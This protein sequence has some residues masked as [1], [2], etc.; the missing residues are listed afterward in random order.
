MLPFCEPYK[1]KMIEPLYRSSRIDRQKWIQD[2]RYNIFN[3]KS[4]QVFIDFLTDSGTGAMSDRQW[5]A[6]MS[7][8]E[9]YAGSRSFHQLKDTIKELTGFNFLLPTHQGRAAENVLFSVLVKEGH[10]VPGNAHFDTT[11]GHI[12]F[13]K[14]TAVDCTID[15][16]YDTTLSHPFK[17]NVN[18]KKLESLLRTSADKVSFILI[19]ATCNTA[20]GQPVS[21]DNIKQVHR[22]AKQYGKLLIM[23]AAR[24]AENAYF[25]KTREEGFK[26]KSI[27][28]IVLEMFSYFDGATMSAKKDGIVNIGGFIALNDQEL[29]REAS[30]F[31]IMFEGFLT[32]G[33]QAGRDM[34][35]LAQGLMESTEFDYLESRI[36]Q[37]AYL[38]GLLKNYGVPVQ[39]PFGGHAIFID[40]LRF[41]P[42]IPREEF[43]GQ[44]LVIELYKS[45]GIRSAEIGSLMADRDPLTRENRFPELELVRLAIPRRTYTNNHMDYTAAAVKSVLDVS[46][47]IRRGYRLT[48]E[49]P[50]MR[51]F[52]MELEPI[53]S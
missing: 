51:H 16:A 19:T 1:I 13:R 24:F 10:L 47:N 3:L 52:T 5:A 50:I 49:A 12:E 28:E 17:G 34:A 43:P 7:A 23:D 35:A 18:I 39:E 26:E 2:A 38:G 30:V 6:I 44:T 27:K 42:Q 29:Y 40:A 41:L 22:L 32:Y 21:M 33:G 9:S 45:G 53:R 15:E 20:G 36:S 48:Y 37:V 46:Q 14:A 31:N 8:D 4:E 25:I 11:K